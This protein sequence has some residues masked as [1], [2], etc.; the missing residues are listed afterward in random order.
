MMNLLILSMKNLVLQFLMM[1][2][3]IE[4][5]QNMWVDRSEI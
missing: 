3:E 5:L 1:L 2:Q 4:M